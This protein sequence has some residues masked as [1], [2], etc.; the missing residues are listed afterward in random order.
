MSE[1]WDPLF[2]R[3]PKWSELY[4]YTQFRETGVAYWTNTGHLAGR[5][6]VRALEAAQ[7]ARHVLQGWTRSSPMPAVR[8]Y[9]ARGT[10]RGN[11]YQAKADLVVNKNWKGAR[12]ARA[13]PSGRLFTRGV[14]RRAV[15]SGWK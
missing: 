3:W 12:A 7:P 10:F 6:G 9:T 8:R 15:L 14:R 11:H 1:N 5:S 2:S 13:A 4:I